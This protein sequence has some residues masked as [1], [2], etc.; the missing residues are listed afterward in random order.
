MSAN[1]PPTRPRVLC[2]EDYYPTIYSRQAGEG[3][4]KITL[5]NGKHGG[6]TR[7]G[8]YSLQ[9]Y[10]Q[11]GDFRRLKGRFWS[12]IFIFSAP[13]CRCGYYIIR[14]RR[15]HQKTKWGVRATSYFPSPSSS[16]SSFIKATLLVTR[17]ASSRTHLLPVSFKDTPLG[18]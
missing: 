16:C 2:V 4:R 13:P 6:G 3:M 10:P 1:H 15:I 11:R 17:D 7:R 5:R 18:Q 14:Q 8:F 12:L 9:P